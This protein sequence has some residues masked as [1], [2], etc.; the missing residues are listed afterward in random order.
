MIIV[1]VSCVFG[2]VIYLAA[3]SYML[4]EE[5]MIKAERENLLK[6]WNLFCANKRNENKTS[7][8]SRTFFEDYT[9]RL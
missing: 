4:Y 8:R 2:V 7:Q 9:E 3:I 6:K 1:I 5:C